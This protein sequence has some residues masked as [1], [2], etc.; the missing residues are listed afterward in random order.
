MTKKKKVA[1]STRSPRQRGRGAGSVPKPTPMAQARQ[2]WGECIAAK[3]FVVL[4][5]DV[6]SAAAR[7]VLREEGLVLPVVG[8]RGWI[9]IEGTTVDPRRVLLA[10]YWPLVSLML[11]RYRRAAIIGIDGVRLQRQEYSVPADLR[12]Y[13]GA[14]ASVHAL[15]LGSGLALRLRPDPLDGAVI[16]EIDVPG[17]GTV[18]VLSDPDLLLTLDEVEIGRDIE[19]VSAWLRHLVVRTPDL[20]AATDARP[21]PQ[22]LQRLADLAEKLGNGPL[23]K[24]LDQAAHRISAK[25]VTPA[26]T[27]VGTRILP[28]PILAQS[29]I[30]TGAPWLDEQAMRL[31]RHVEVAGTIIDPTVIPPRPLADRIAAAREAKAYDAYHNTTMEGY[32]IAPEVVDAIVRGAPPPGGPRS[33]EELRA[34]MA[35]QGYSGAFDEVL[36]LVPRRPDVT[37]GVVLDL[38]E[39]LFRPSV[40]AGIVAPGE[41]RR[42]RNG[43]VGLAGWR[44]VPPNPVKLSDLMRGLEEFGA[45]RDVDPLVKALTLHLEF[46][47]IHP[48]FDGN[49]RLGR[50]LM[51]LLLL[52]NDAPWVTIPVDQRTPF[53]QSIEVAQVDGAVEQ[54]LRFV[55]DAVCRAASRSSAPPATGRRR[56]R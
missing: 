31:A 25:R 30:G 33:E 48:F 16:D 47:T 50:L 34:A 45:R 41:L 42:W 40:D 35:V 32:R 49:G 13:Q 20:R 29:P 21:R 8:G 15:K 1:R 36:R 28:P 10:N 11:R 18:P 3:R 53:F 4:P 52:S 6:P 51:N 12:A 46:V 43:P 37:Q 44:H 56:G 24:Q 23:A 22:V 55:W 39:A 54:Y 19:G 27:G 26:R 38:Y 17:G 2:W 14:N 5:S 7:L 9:L